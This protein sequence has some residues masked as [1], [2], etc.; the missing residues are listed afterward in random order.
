MRPDKIL[1]TTLRCF[2]RYQNW[3]DIMF[4]IARKQPP[5]RILLRNGACF[6]SPETLLGLID[7]I[8]FEHIYTLAALQVEPDDIV[9]DIG[10]HM[11][12]FTVFAALM[13]HNSVYA[14]EPSPDNLEALKR[15]IALN[16]LNNVNAQGCAVSDTVGRA[17]LLISPQRSTRHLLA[18][19][20]SL[21]T[22]TSYQ[23]N[24][25]NRQFKSTLPGELTVCVE[26][27]TTSLQDIMDSNNLEQIDFLKLDCEGAEGMIVS[28]TPQAYLKRIKKIAI[29][30]HDHLSRIPHEEIRHLLEEAGFSTALRWDGQSPLG[31]LYAWRNSPS[32]SLDR[33]R[34]IE[35]LSKYS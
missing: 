18:D 15:N 10:A 5:T 25:A 21:D 1:R 23:A 31:Y 27:P 11:G 24:S 34:Q 3:L 2:H 29:E 9:V 13:T 17:A 12:V 16:R 26:V 14:F 19:R 7:E 35:K 20:S 32:R 30:F 6:E 8:F 28:S 4:S 22:L 33:H